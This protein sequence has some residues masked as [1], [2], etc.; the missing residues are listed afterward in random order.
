[1]IFDWQLYTLNLGQRSRFLF[2]KKG[3]FSRSIPKDQQ[4]D[5]LINLEDK[6]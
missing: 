3:F 1:M 2:I 6:L 4:H 5:Q